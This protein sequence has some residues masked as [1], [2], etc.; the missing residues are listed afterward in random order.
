M[1][2]DHISDALDTT[3]AFSCENRFLLSVLQID[4]LFG[5]V[6]ESVEAVSL[7][8]KAPMWKALFTSKN[9]N[10]EDRLQ[11]DFQGVKSQQNSDR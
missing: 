3:L 9:E 8:N 10:Q 1:R 2:L 11:S 5:N 6:V 4:L 7:A